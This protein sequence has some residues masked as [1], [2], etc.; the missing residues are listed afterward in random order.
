MVSGELE[1]ASGSLSLIWMSKRVIVRGRKRI[2]RLVIVGNFGGERLSFEMMMM[3]MAGLRD[4]SFNLSHLQTS[5]RRTTLR[6]EGAGHL[7]AINSRLHAWPRNAP[8]H[9]T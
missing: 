1:Q 7:M 2:A 8:A 3:P 9:Y 5:D 4:P 6:G